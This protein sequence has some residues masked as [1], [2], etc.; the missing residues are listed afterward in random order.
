MAL[1]MSHTTKAG[2][3]H[4]N[5][6]WL[7]SDIDIFKKF[8][9]TPD[10]LRASLN[11]EDGE[12]PEI[13][14]PARDRE[15]GYFLHLTVIG[16]ASETARSD[17]DAPIAAVYRYPTKHPTHETVMDTYEIVDMDGFK[18]DTSLSDTMYA[19]AYAHLK[20]LDFFSG[21]VDA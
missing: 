11:L 8:Q 4:A 10:M 19:Q 9:N 18:W 1:T 6:Y 17:G 5:S 16:W 13:Q 3:T 15:A 2:V 20:T 21:A 14:A 7:I 12:Q